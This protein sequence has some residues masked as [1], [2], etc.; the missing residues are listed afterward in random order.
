MAERDALR[1]LCSDHFHGLITTEAYRQ[2]RGELLNAAILGQ[3]TRLE[4]DDQSTQTFPRASSVG[5]A[6][7][8]AS[9]PPATA[10]HPRKTAA[11][12]LG[13][14]LVGAL[15][16]FI[17]WLF[18]AAPP[19]PRHRTEVASAQPTPAMSAGPSTAGQDGFVIHFIDVNSWDEAAFSEFMFEW[20]QLSDSGRDAVRQSESFRR[21]TQQLRSRVLEAR[22]LAD[23]AN[24]ASIDRFHLVTSFAR[25]LGLDPGVADISVPSTVKKHRVVAPR[26]PVA[27]A[28]TSSAASPQSPSAKTAARQPSSVA[29]PDATTS[30]EAPA[31]PPAT[32]KTSAALAAPTDTA[33]TQ[34]TPPALYP[35]ARGGR[36]CR[37]EMVASRPLATPDRR[38]CYDLIAEGV[39]GPLLVVLPAGK[40]MMGSTDDKTTE[41]VH[42]VTIANPFA[43]SVY[44]I[45]VGDFRRFC[46]DRARDCKLAPIADDD[47][48]VADVTWNDAVA[49]TAWLSEKTGTRYRLPTEAEWEYAARAGTT[50]R[51]PFGD[52]INQA[53]AAF[54]MSEVDGPMPR[55]RSVVA[56]EFGLKHMVGNVR[57]WVADAWRGDY[58]NAPRDGSAVKGTGQRVTRGGAY[59]DDKRAV[60]SAARTPMDAG[61]ATADTGFRVLRE[62]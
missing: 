19:T 23:P 59:D 37:R 12:G 9:P 35:A 44:E 6:Q 25:E 30:A 53:Q 5:D 24:R 48:P 39:R 7:A 22:A 36:P 33:A 41:P 17:V 15:V 43:L 10:R 20:D 50:T 4:E 56:N 16:A 47:Y 31:S 62:L 40:F 45:T 29:A 13:V 11:I 2:R 57:E 38:S 58:V 28:R 54:G 32:A 18:A 1:E 14:V 21:L 49:Y 55:D 26:E 60:T 3:T 27:E 42:S 51:Y 52:D 8:A 34:S 61:A 46:A